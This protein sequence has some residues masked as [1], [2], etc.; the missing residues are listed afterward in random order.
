MVVRA[1]L[2]LVLLLTAHA[3]AWGSSP[4]KE[5]ASKG[6]AAAEVCASPA[7]GADDR[8]TSQVQQLTE[9]VGSQ[10]A[11]IAQLERMLA[12][13][14]TKPAPAQKGAAAAAPAASL[15][16]LQPELQPFRLAEAQRALRRQQAQLVRVFSATV[17][18]PLTAVA[19]S[20]QLLEKGLPHLPRLT[21]AADSLGVLHLFDS[22]GG[23]VVRLLTRTHAP[24]PPY[25][26]HCACG[27]R[28]P[29]S[30][31]STLLG[32]A[33]GTG[34]LVPWGGGGGGGRG[35]GEGSGSY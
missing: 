11:R 7:A 21:A 18:A 35:E 16:D 23:E 6:P 20:T 1:T 34:Q 17:G 22:D 14:P 30:R 32:I 12:A 13:K 28:T 19:L 31:I 29:A 2:T 10:A 26:A 3:E 27:L 8:L 33:H 25:C 4:K 15:A 9:A 5:T 24:G